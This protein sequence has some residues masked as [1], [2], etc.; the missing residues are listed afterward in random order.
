MSRTEHQRETAMKKL[1]HPLRKIFLW[2]Y[3]R[4]TWQY[5]LLVALIIAT[6]FLVPGQFFGDRDRPLKKATQ[7][8]RRW[9]IEPNKINVFAARS[10]K[11]ETLKVA[12]KEVV[13]LYLREVIQPDI[14]VA[15]CKVETDKGG[16]ITGYSVWFQ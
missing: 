4:G 7:E 1:L 16:K 13:Q 9:S 2:S 8:I 3:E 5:D 15:D 12:P 6:V 11:A 10:G 14:E